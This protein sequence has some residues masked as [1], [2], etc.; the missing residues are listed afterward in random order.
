MNY[1]SYKKK[2]YFNLIE[3]LNISH[4]SLI[5]GISSVEVGNISQ[6][7]PGS[8]IKLIPNGI[9]PKQFPEDEDFKNFLFQKFP[10]L[11]KERI[12]LFL[13]R[14]DP[15]KG[16]DLL[17][18]AFAQVREHISN[19][20]LIIAGPDNIGYLPQVKKYFAEAGCL[21]SVT[22]P[23][24][25]SGELKYSALAGAEI[26][27]SPSYSEGFSMSILEGMAS[28]LPCIIT[29]GCNFPE[30]QEANAACVVGPDVGA[31]SAALITYLQ[32]PRSAKLMG[33]RARD[34]VRREYTLEAV[35]FQLI[36][37]YGAILDSA[38]STRKL[39]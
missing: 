6:L 21:D 16:L 22:F 28:G 12:I 15:K 13:G 24:M 9:N 35:S 39:R 29:K 5:H 11:R 31:I 8:D 14:I 26:Y 25:L 23:G 10:H 30:A 3:R 7:L 20:H 36:E 4:A 2:A 37:A 33:S 32:D 17:A 1:K 27:I 34:F 38:F 19:I 18:L